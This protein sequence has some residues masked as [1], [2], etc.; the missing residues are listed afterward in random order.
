ME[1]LDENDQ[2]AIHILYG[3]VVSVVKIVR[4]NEQI[5]IVDDL[6]KEIQP[7]NMDQTT[8][9]EAIRSIFV[10]LGIEIAYSGKGSNEKGVVIDMDESR[11]NEFGLDS[12]TI[13]FGQTVIR[14]DN[15]QKQI[16]GKTN[17]LKDIDA[18]DLP[19]LIDRLIA[20][21]INKS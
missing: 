2:E 14:T 19:T 20:M 21:A 17:E 15:L 5:L 13:R 9:R 18:K 10:E 3:L 4:G 16:I 11:I 6:D 12:D 8:T 1:L 7:I